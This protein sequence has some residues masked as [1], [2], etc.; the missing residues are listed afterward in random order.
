MEARPSCGICVVFVHLLWF[1]IVVDDDIA[2]IA[3]DQFSS[4]ALDLVLEGVGEVGKLNKACGRNWYCDQ[5]LS[6]TLLSSFLILSSLTLNS[7][8]EKIQIKFFSSSSSLIS[9]PSGAVLLQFSAIPV[10]ICSMVE[11]VQW[12]ITSRVLGQVEV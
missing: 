11:M 5:N 7:C 8:K 6:A 4:T 12:W 2:V 9:I 10:A 1:F 3:K